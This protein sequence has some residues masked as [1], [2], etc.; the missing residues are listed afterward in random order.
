MSASPW[1]RVYPGWYRNREDSTVYVGKSCE[2]HY[3]GCSFKWAV[4]TET[5]GISEMVDSTYEMTRSQ[6]YEY[7]QQLIKR[8]AGE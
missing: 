3:S 1:E 7:A 6:A 2:C 8:K 4:Y 5:D